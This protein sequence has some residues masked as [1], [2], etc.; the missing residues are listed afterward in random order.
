MANVRSGAKELV[1]S[2]HGVLCINVDP[3]LAIVQYGLEVAD[4]GHLVQIVDSI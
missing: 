1:P 2:V 3:A 4:G